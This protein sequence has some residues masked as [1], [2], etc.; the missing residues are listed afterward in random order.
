MA[1]LLRDAGFPLAR[2]I[3]WL[4]RDI[5]FDTRVT[6]A[7]FD[8]DAGQTDVACPRLDATPGR[9]PNRAGEDRV[10]REEDQ[11][12]T[13]DDRHGHQQELGRQAAE[14]WQAGHQSSGVVAIADAP[15]LRPV[16][17]ARAPTA[18]SRP[19]AA[20]QVKSLGATFVAAEA[21]ATGLSPSAKR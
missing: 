11:G 19:A 8:E 16:R 14:A 18:R 15:I 10:P 7:R 20:E 9:E 1:S 13:H 17:P 21:L 5:A 4:R 6:T 3:P 12:E 2:A